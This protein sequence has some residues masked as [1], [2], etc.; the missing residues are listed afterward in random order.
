MIK[1]IQACDHGA[2]VVAAPW[3]V[4]VYL[5]GTEMLLVVDTLLICI[6]LYEAVPNVNCTSRRCGRSHHLVAAATAACLGSPTDGLV[7]KHNY[8]PMGTDMDTAIPADEAAPPNHVHTG[9]FDCAGNPVR[10]PR[11]QCARAGGSTGC[12]VRERSSGITLV[13]AT[14]K[15]TRGNLQAGLRRAAVRQGTM[16]TCP[17]WYRT[18]LPRFVGTTQLKAAMQT[19]MRASC[20][21][22]AMAIKP[23]S[24]ARKHDTVAQ[25]EIQ[26]H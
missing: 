12:R 14:C 15:V 18:L 24:T 5:D 13:G 20:P 16:H 11:I 26:S 3:T 21:R 17:Q 9:G 22:H 1:V 19:C 6:D 23:M 2:A 8:D 7:A 25:C 10:V 4:R